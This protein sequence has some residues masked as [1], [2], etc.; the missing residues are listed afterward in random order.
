ML[1]FFGK[2]ALPTSEQTAS[3]AKVALTKDYLLTSQ[4]NSSKCVV[5]K[6][7]TLTGTGTLSLLHSLTH[8]L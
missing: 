7:L 6:T 2:R 1:L 3:S 4:V 8:S 5:S